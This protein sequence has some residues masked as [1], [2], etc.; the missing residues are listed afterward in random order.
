MLLPQ[1]I[2]AIGELGAAEK[3]AADLDDVELATI[4]VAVARSLGPDATNENINHIATDV[5]S[6]V[7]S[8]VHCYDEIAGLV[9]A[10]PAV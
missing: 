3:E 9:V 1:G 8:A 10:P 2:K 4:K 6:M 7:L 5:A